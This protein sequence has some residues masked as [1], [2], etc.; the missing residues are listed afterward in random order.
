[1][2]VGGEFDDDTKDTS[3]NTKERNDMSRFDKVIL[4]FFTLP[5]TSSLPQLED[6]AKKLYSA[7]KIFKLSSGIL[8]MARRMSIKLRTGNGEWG[9][10]G[11]KF[12]RNFKLGKFKDKFPNSMSYNLK[13][14][15]A[16]SFLYYRRRLPRGL[17]KKMESDYLSDKRGGKRIH[18][19][20]SLMN[21]HKDLG[22]ELFAETF[23][24]SADVPEVLC[25]GME[26]I[27]ERNRLFSPKPEWQKTP[28]G[29]AEPQNPIE[30]GDKYAVL[31]LHHVRLSWLLTDGF[32]KH[33]MDPENID[34]KIT[35]AVKEKGMRSTIF[36]SGNAAMIGPMA[37]YMEYNHDIPGIEITTKKDFGK[38]TVRDDVSRFDIAV[39]SIDSHGEIF[40]EREFELTNP[41][42]K[43]APATY[44]S[45]KSKSNLQFFF[46]A[47]LTHLYSR[48]PTVERGFDRSQGPLIVESCELDADNED[49]VNAGV[50][51]ASLNWENVS[52]WT[53]Q[54]AEYTFDPEVGCT[55]YVSSFGDA[56]NPSKY[57][58]S[59]AAVIKNDE[60]ARAF[61]RRKVLAHDS[62]HMAL[63][64][65][66][67]EFIDVKERKFLQGV[68]LRF[69]WN[70]DFYQEGG[71][72][73]FLRFPTLEPIDFYVARND[74]NYRG[75]EDTYKLP[76]TFNL[77]GD[78]FAEKNRWISAA[79]TGEMWEGRAEEFGGGLN[80]RAL[81]YEPIFSDWKNSRKIDQFEYQSEDLWVNSHPINVDFIFNEVGDALAAE[82]GDIVSPF[83]GKNVGQ[84]LHEIVDFEDVNV[85]QH[86]LHGTAFDIGTRLL[87]ITEDEHRFWPR[88][89]DGGADLEN[90][91]RM[92]WHDVNV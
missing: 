52:L 70:Y 80:K 78:R 71:S 42:P 13:P 43:R 66:F 6:D 16:R 76:T 2:G 9:E 47:I 41:T 87:S 85:M 40:T 17:V 1:M 61:G 46:P 90:K 10:L 24:H 81:N 21:E 49:K 91:I 92:A 26:I 11:D 31:K 32:A 84:E 58:S 83:D 56:N 63:D 39:S 68:N 7:L 89:T 59:I 5:S 20:Q 35:H 88:S 33:L 18:M 65:E 75:E 44:F 8:D 25:F 67:K 54:Y 36:A 23:A 64:D 73:G 15:H 19:H 22:K 3:E 60:R 69:Q 28:L 74:L 86:V 82:F 55:D 45:T 38:S 53:S 29:Q 48:F 4:D 51:P 34:E 77:L 30:N 27:G 79:V 57:D 37:K 50:K 12:R 62:R 14:T 72:V